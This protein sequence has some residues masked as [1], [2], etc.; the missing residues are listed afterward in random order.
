LRS[1]A[2]TGHQKRS[3]A[4]LIKNRPQQRLAMKNYQ[5][6][7]GTLGEKIALKYLQKLGYQ[8]LEKNFHQRD[9]ELDLIMKRGQQITFFEIKTRRLTT[10][11]STKFGLPDEQISWHQK[12]ALIKTARAFLQ[13]RA[14]PYCPWQFDLISINLDLS[15]PAIPKVKIQ[16]L[17][18]IFAE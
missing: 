8:L 16:H 13:L 9:G 4:F 6:K 17:Q 1:P 7:L 14:L 2:Q 5:K 3:E 18:D 12:I 11:S 10:A 15:R